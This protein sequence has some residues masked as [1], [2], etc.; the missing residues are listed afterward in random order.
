MELL[1]LLDSI[2]DDAPSGV[3]LRNDPR[4]HAIERLLGPAAR[5]NRLNPD[6]TLNESAPDVDWQDVLD[7]AVALA[8]DGR[9][10][11][12]LVIL[13]R[14]VAAVEDFDGLAQG[15]GLLK[16]TLAG[17]WDTLHPELR[18]RDDAKA[19]ALPR[20]NALKQ[21][22]NDDNGLL[23]D[24][25]YSIILNMR[26][27]G[28]ISGMDL[29]E[30]S[31]SDFE[32]LN[33][34]PSGLNE[35]EK[36]LL[37]EQH[38]KVVNR[39]NAA[40]RALAAEEAERA[41]ETIAAIGRCEASITDL[42]AQFSQSGG[43]GSDMALSLSELSEFLEQVRTTFEA[44]VSAMSDDAADESD[45]PAAQNP[46]P[47]AAPSASGASSANGSA[48][49]APGAINSRRDVEKSL[50][51]IVSFYERT[52]PSSP[53]PHLARRMRR[54]VAMDFLELME[55]IAPSGLKEFSSV[56]GVDVKKK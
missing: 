34:A 7:Q 10:L 39:V 51:A 33:L 41:A 15:L 14:A 32:H 52:E 48:A 2:S 47:T 1:G 35:T 42:C 56:A 4:F 40:C 30:A 26:G 8:K 6:G 31:L 17:H 46:T 5:E 50:D 12:L 37:S 27:L 28:A 16:D 45:T 3:E 18:E 55:E 36:A 9:D 43:F 19:A 54:M 22:E 21:L 23:G 13:V 24:L 25:K 38:S 20:I 44:G 29:A 49:V 53:I 11:R